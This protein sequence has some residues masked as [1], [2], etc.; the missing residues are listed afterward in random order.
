[1]IHL[2]KGATQ[3]LILTLKEK[4]TLAAPYFLFVFTQRTTGAEIKFTRSSD[5]SPYP[6]R[7]NEFTIIVNNYFKAA[8]LGEWI[9]RVYESASNTTNTAGLYLLEEGI[10]RLND[11]PLTYQSRKAKLNYVTR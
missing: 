11:Q 8:E 7:Y 4:Q 2:T 3:K 10:M 5:E 1:M 6:D 9:Y